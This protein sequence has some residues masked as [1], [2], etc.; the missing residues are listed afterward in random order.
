MLSNYTKE[1]RRAAE[2]LFH[3]E[4][5]FFGQNSCPIYEK[6][7]Y[8]ELSMRHTD[9]EEISKVCENMTNSYIIFKIIRDVLS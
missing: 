2:S 6:D 4:E 7:I 3:K 5:H 8:N 9:H 1:P